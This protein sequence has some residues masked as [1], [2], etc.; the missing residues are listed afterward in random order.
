MHACGSMLVVL[1]VWGFFTF[2]SHLL[3][4]FFYY[5]AMQQADSTIESADL[6]N[7][8]KH[9]RFTTTKHTLNH[10]LAYYVFLH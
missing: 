10:T 4:D 8:R 3:N 6:S 9:E 1:F 5:V 7:R 2:S